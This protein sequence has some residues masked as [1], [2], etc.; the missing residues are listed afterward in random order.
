MDFRR[1]ISFCRLFGNLWSRSRMCSNK[2][3][4]PTPLPRRILFG[5]V[6]QPNDL[7]DRKRVSNR[8][9]RNHETPLSIRCSCHSRVLHQCLHI[10]RPTNAPTNTMVTTSNS[11][12]VRPFHARIL[13]PALRRDA[14]SKS[15]RHR[16]AP[17]QRK[18]VRT[19]AQ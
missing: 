8:H 4:Y 17:Q 19:R 11:F 15:E 12:R 6:S 2:L 10:R 9:L 14:R 16:G 3:P 18:N 5:S 13:L 1:Q 7:H